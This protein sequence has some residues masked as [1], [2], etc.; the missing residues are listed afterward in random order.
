MNP[1]GV[2]RFLLACSLLA[3]SAAWSA[4]HRADLLLQRMTKAVESLSYEGIFVYIHGKKTE[5][6][7]IVHTRDERGQR[8]HLLSLTGEPREVIRDDNILTCI[9]PASR[10]VVIEPRRSRLGG[11]PAAIPDRGFGPDSPYRFTLGEEQ[12]IAGLP[13]R[14]VSIEPHDDLRYAHRLC[15]DE[16]SG[17]LLKSEMLDRDGVI[18]EQFMFTNIQFPVRVSDERFQP[19]MQGDGFRT[20]RVENQSGPDDLPPDPDWNVRD[21]P[22]GFDL[23]SVTKRLMAA[24]QNPVQHMVLSDGLATVSVFISRAPSL[25]DLYVGATQSGA[26]NAMAVPSGDYQVTVVGEVPS[27]TVRMIAESVVHEGKAR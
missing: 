23:V 19:V 24:N 18:I 27:D 16:E 10:A 20:Y 22:P 11:L 25:D 15:I 4:D 14:T 5:T 26:L 3:S 6:M 8:E 7:Q 17:M 1:T 2:I 9:W 21:I 12:R 13:C